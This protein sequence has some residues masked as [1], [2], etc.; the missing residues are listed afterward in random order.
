MVSRTGDNA[1]KV[2]HAGD[3][4]PVRHDHSGTRD[5]HTL[6]TALHERLVVALQKK[7]TV[8]ESEGVTVQESEGV[9]VQESEGVTV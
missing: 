3:A 9:T 4:V 5:V 1:A 2:V 7:C 8:R 6:Q